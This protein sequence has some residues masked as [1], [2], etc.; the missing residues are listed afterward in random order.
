[1]QIWDREMLKISDIP[2]GFI[3]FLVV[4]GCLWVLMGVWIIRLAWIVE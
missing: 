1:M 4:I 3:A 2:A